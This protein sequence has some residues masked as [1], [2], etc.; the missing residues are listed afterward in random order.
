MSSIKLR[1][2]SR[3]LLTALCLTALLPLSRASAEPGIRIL[4][5]LSTADL[6]FNA[7]TTN[8]RSLEALTSQPLTTYTFEADAR[9]RHQLEDPA[10]RNVMHYLVECALPAT[11]TVEWMDRKKEVH[12]F[13]GGVGLCPEWG[14]RAPS[15]QCL[16]YVSAC[17]L[18][19]NN[20]YG[21]TV[22]IS[23]RG[24]HPR[25][26]RRFN[27]T[28]VT[29]QWHPMFLPCAHGG[30]GAWEE[31]GWVGEGVGSCTPGEQ[32]T[33]AAGAPR[34]D[35]SCTTTL[36]SGD[37]DRV[38]RVCAQ[39]RGCEAASAL[40]L[41]EGN[42]CGGAQPSATFTCPRGGRYSVM[43][44]PYD[45]SSPPGSW[46][47]PA[48]TH[49]RYPTESFGAFT[50]REGAFFGNILDPKGLNVEVHINMD[51]YAPFLSKPDFDGY[52]YQ[53]AHAC[54]SRD[55][56]AGD[57]HLASRVCANTVVGGRNAYGCLARTVGPCEPDAFT[58]KAACDVNDGPVVTADGDFEVCADTE[59]TY[60][61]ESIT[62]V[63][64]SPCDALPPSDR[65][66]C[67]PA[68]CDFSYAPPR[69]KKGCEQRSAS[70]CLAVACVKNPKLC[71][72][73]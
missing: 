35:T 31:C 64:N 10:A 13:S 67:D 27:P 57:V 9:L 63:L 47:R 53:N 56:V 21:H 61:F 32:V 40:A 69:C 25:D 43:S 70:Q 49:G 59:G 50:F 3:L 5:S 39:P 19:R 17:L 11:A 66:T 7:L 34:L 41:G 62:T 55:W 29:Q 2:P 14:V 46:V 42:E 51:T 33:I 44:A 60:H 1:A 36:G 45:R 23:M 37:G 72:K 6:A 12:S 38:L 54:Y 30:R 28:G 52:P 20:A 71:G 68:M 24:E 26:D 73:K 8:A 58:S 22:E 16:G 15:A 65:V 48:V 4:N 18:S